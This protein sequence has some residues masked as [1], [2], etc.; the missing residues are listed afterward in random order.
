MRQF[1]FIAAVVAT[2]AILF[3]ATKPAS[4]AANPQ[5]KGGAAVAFAKLLVATNSVGVTTFGGKGTVAINELVTTPG[6]ADIT[7]TGKYPKGLTA[8]Q[9]VLILTTEPGE[10]GVANGQVVSASATQLVIH[11]T[12]FNAT[13]GNA[14]SQPIFLTVFIGQT[15]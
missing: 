10:F 15:F 2:V 3:I 5:S 9:V 6:S 8:D 7:F 1:T 4:A 12:S 14:Q 13:T 11:V